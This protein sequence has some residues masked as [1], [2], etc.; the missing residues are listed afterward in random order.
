MYHVNFN[1]SGGLCYEQARKSSGKQAAKKEK[2]GQI[3][4]MALAVILFLGLANLLYGNMG[5]A[6]DETD[7]IDLERSIAYID[8]FD[9]TYVHVYPENEV[10][11][12]EVQVNGRSLEENPGRNMWSGNF[13]GYSRGEEL[14]VTITAHKNGERVQELVLIV[15]EMAD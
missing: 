6:S 13:L 4:F 1:N 10:A 7:L 8:F 9:I 5:G 15:E 2:T 3:F 11:P 14:T 12:A